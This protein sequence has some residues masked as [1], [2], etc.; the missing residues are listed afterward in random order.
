MKLLPW[1]F[2]GKST[3]VGCHCLLP[4]STIQQYKI[5]IK[6]KKENQDL[7][8]VIKWNMITSEPG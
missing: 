2:P 1:D 8:I 4:I 5:K 7:S 6:L 3:G